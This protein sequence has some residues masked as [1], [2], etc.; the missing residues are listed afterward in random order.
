MPPPPPRFQPKLLPGRAQLS[1]WL[2]GINRFNP[3]LT[4]N[5]PHKDSIDFLEQELH[6]IGGL[7]IHRDVLH[8]KQRPGSIRAPQNWSS[9]RRSLSVWRQAKRR[10][11]VFSYRLFDRRETHRFGPRHRADKDL[12]RRGCLPP[13]SSDRLCRGAPLFR[14]R[15]LYVRSGSRID[16]S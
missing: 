16:P 6:R 12:S 2:K 11:R 7:H 13:R 1:K 4:G 9:R 3:R 10:P 15:R 14:L 5:G 8:L